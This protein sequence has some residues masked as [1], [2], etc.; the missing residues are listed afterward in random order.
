M[1]TDRNHISIKTWLTYYSKCSQNSCAGSSLLTDWRNL[2]SNWLEKLW[3]SSTVL[4]GHFSLK[5]SKCTTQFSCQMIKFWQC[6]FL[7]PFFFKI[8]VFLLHPSNHQYW[9]YRV[10]HLRMCF[11]KGLKI[12]S[13]SKNLKFRGQGRGSS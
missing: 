13:S 7:S 10:F 8:T 9:S 3:N 5:F 11:L 4:Q 2:D 1:R 12:T 6:T